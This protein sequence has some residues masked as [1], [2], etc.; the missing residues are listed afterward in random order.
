[1]A[2]TAQ[3]IEAHVLACT[4]ELYPETDM[5]ARQTTTMGRLLD[6]TNDGLRQKMF[7]GLWYQPPY[8]EDFETYFGLDGAE[9]AY[10]F[11]MNK[12]GLS[13]VLY[14]SEYARARTN[15]YTWDAW[16]RDPAAQAR[17]Q[18]AQIQRQQLLSC[19][20]KP[21]GSGSPTP[22]PSPDPSKTCE[23]RSFEGLYEFGGR[24]MIQNALAEGFKISVETNLACVLLTA[25]PSATDFQGQL[26]IGAYRCR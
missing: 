10:V 18:A 21:G 12:P 5:T 6:E 25:V 16:Q 23:Y 3:E 24:E 20:N 15:Q 13:S 7:K 4:P 9:A 1:M 26:K 19:F 17:W 14:T 11:C 22:A 8:T 2:P